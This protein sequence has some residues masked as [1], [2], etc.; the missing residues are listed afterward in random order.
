MLALRQ[1]GEEGLGHPPRAEEVELDRL[2]SRFELD[3]RGRLLRVVDTP[4]V[5]DEDIEAPELL[6]D[7]ASRILDVAVVRDVE[8]DRDDIAGGCEAASGGVA[9]VAAA[10]AEQHDEATS[11]ELARH[12]EADAAV[13]SSNERDGGE[14]SICWHLAL[15]SIDHRR[16]PPACLNPTARRGGSD[17]GPAFGGVRRLVG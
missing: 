1:Q 14:S 3:R 7:Q 15:L 2:V 4:G 11:G 5:V 6:L 13:R 12:L 16:E 9:S 8:A 10:A 17:A